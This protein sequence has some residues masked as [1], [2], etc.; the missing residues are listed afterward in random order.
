MSFDPI[1]MSACAIAGAVNE[2]SVRAADVASAFLERTEDLHRELNTHVFWDK[3]A[4]Q[5]E[6]EKQ[7]DYIEAAR[8]AQKPLPLAGVP[9][10]I[11]DNIMADGSIVSCGSKFLA[12]HRAA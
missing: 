2:G 8:R 4:V 9:F 3:A 6:T 10:A 5:N 1:Q 11:K 7:L 12:N